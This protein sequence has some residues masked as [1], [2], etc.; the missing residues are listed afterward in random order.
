MEHFLTSSHLWW[1]KRRAGSNR[2][3]DYIACVVYHEVFLRTADFPNG[4]LNRR[5]C[6]WK[7]VRHRKRGSLVPSLKTIVGKLL[8]G[9]LASRSW[10]C[11]TCLSQCSSVKWVTTRSSGW[12]HQGLI[13]S[14]LWRSF[15]VG[16]NWVKPHQ[17]R[18]CSEWS[19][20]RHHQNRG[21]FTWKVPFLGDS[22]KALKGGVCCASKEI[23]IKL[24]HGHTVGVKTERN[25]PGLLTAFPKDYHHHVM[26]SLPVPLWWRTWCCLPLRSLRSLA[27]IFLPGRLQLG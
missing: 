27:S 12:Y 10:I 23:K 13:V 3:F 19:Y 6:F 9:F 18:K 21:W 15:V 17:L 11:L 7:A 1:G 2:T 14:V 22:L 20:N 25:S 24:P 26:A 4:F 8:K 5:R 16:Y